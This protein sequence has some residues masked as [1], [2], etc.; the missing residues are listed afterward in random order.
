MQV[1]NDERLREIL[2][3]AGRSESTGAAVPTGF[4]A[5]VMRAV[6]AVRPEDPLDA[7]AAGLWRAALSSAG[8][9][10]VVGVAALFLGGYSEERMGGRRGAWGFQGDAWKGG[11]D[12]LA[13]AWIDDSLIDDPWGDG[14]SIDEL[15]SGDLW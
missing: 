13:Q 10:A 8:V 6:R 7:W 14:P 5:R 1:M 15:K 12:E 4:E 9:A 2:I 11:G 3:R